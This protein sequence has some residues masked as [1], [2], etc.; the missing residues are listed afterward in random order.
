MKSKGTGL[1]GR[2][3]IAQ[4]MQ[5]GFTIAADSSGRQQKPT[6]RN[7]TRET[8]GMVNQFD[9]ATSLSGKSVYLNG[10]HGETGQ[11]VTV[12]IPVKHHLSEQALKALKTKTGY[13]LQS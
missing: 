3:T 9:A 10:Q 13:D 11:P 7:N 1:S 8:R 4:L 6:Q 2:D 12:F 5:Q